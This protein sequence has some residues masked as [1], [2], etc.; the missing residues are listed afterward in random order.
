MNHRTEDLVRRD[1]ETYVRQFQVDGWMFVDAGGR[2]AELLRPARR[3]PLIAGPSFGLAT[4]LVASLAYGLI[5]GLFAA[6]VAGLVAW[7]VSRLLGL[8]KAVERLT[9]EVTDD[10]ELIKERKLI[11]VSRY[12]DAVAVNP[13]DRDAH[14]RRGIANHVLGQYAAAIADFNRVVELDPNNT[15]GYYRR[16]LVQADEGA[17]DDAIGD[18]NQALSVTDDA[19]DIA[20]IEKLIEDLRQ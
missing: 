17:I 14:Y 4:G 11:R 13:G 10:G 2:D 8:H 7:V 18:L 1:L 12:E 19:D 16:A 6:L 20:E 5:V 9:I 15:D 3:R